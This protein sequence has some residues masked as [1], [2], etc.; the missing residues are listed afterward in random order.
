VAVDPAYDALLASVNRADINKARD[1]IAADPGLVKPET[2]IVLAIR[3]YD[4]GERDEAVFWYYAGRDRFLT[5]EAVLDM[6]SLMLIKSAEVV[7]GFLST[8][9]PDI[10]GY[11]YCSIADQIET[12][13]R[14]IAWVAAHPYKLLGYT[15]L[16]ALAEDR[17]AAL[18]AAV[19]YMRENAAHKRK[20]FDDPAT[21]ARI[22]DER[23]KIHAHERF[24]WR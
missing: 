11:A 23:L 17:N 7:D 1:A 13:D 6:R 21:L 19:N 9:G 24:C 22:D 12:E 15:Q 16:P 20:S 8:V 3:L 10:D 2:L 5:M 18:A 4:V 14:A